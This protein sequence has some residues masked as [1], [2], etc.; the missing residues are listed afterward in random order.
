MDDADTKPYDPEDEE[1][2]YDP[3]A[4]IFDEK[5]PA[6]SKTTSGSTIASKKEKKLSSRAGE[7]AFS[8]DGESPS[9]PPPKS[10]ISCSLLSKYLHSVPNVKVQGLIVVW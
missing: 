1:E 9:P 4:V 6:T 10:K 8:S 7:P 5:K 2:I 3:E